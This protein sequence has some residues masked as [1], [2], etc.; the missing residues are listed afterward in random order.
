[1]P[2][3]QS[4]FF[5]Q[6]Y[7]SILP[8]S[9]AYIVPSTRGCSPWRPNAVMSTTGC[10]WHSVLQ[11]FK[12]RWERTGHHVTC[13]ALPAARPYLRLS[14]FQGGQA[15]KQKKITL[16]ETPADVSGLP[17]IAVDRHIPDRLTH[18]QVP[19]TWNLSP[20]RP[21]KFSFEYLLLPP[22][23]APTA[24]PPGL[25]PKV[26]QRPPRLPTQRGLA[27]A[28]TARSLDGIHRPIWAAFPNNPTRRQRL[29]VRQGPGTTGLSP[30]LAPPSRG[31]GPGFDNDPFAGSP[32]ES[33]LLLLLP[34]NDK[35]QPGSI[36][37]QRRRRISPACLRGRDGF[38][39]SA[40]VVCKE[41]RT[42]QIGADEGPMPTAFAA[43]ENSDR[44]S[45]TIT[46]YDEARESWD[47][48]A[49]FRFAPRTKCE[50][51]RAIDK[52]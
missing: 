42:G 2:S 16:P 20:L 24:A 18:V 52:T 30:S 36:P 22:R 35:D 28:P 34:L 40:T 3:P 29:V 27:L 14:R 15:V 21:S 41:R 37:H 9:L 4:Q 47:A 19:F 11:I 26:L 33:L 49:A 39:V 38:K 48:R 51:R 45:W 10:V 12:G 13:G 23:S 1:M 7:G 25:A 5:S 31:L 32:T 17:N 50:G 46:S 44:C 43:S 8:T 6:N